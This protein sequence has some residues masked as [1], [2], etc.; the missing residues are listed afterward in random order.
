[1]GEHHNDALV[2]NKKGV[3]SDV[4][5]F[6][7]KF[8]PWSAVIRAELVSGGRGGKALLVSTREDKHFIKSEKTLRL[9]RERILRPETVIFYRLL[10]RKPAEIVDLI[11]EGLEQYNDTK[12]GSDMVEHSLESYVQRAA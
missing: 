6:D 9:E 2:I 7:H 12:Q 1:M 11:N 5:G 10:N 4:S 8:I 3:W